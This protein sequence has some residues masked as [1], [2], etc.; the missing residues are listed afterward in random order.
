MRDEVRERIHGIVVVIVFVD[1]V[2]FSIA[3]FIAV[4]QTKKNVRI[5]FS[6]SR[7]LHDS[8]GHFTARQSVRRLVR[9]K[10]V[11]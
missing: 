10:L 1:V 11:L 6:F 9:L 8:I 3:Q 5:M 4:E 7:V 2:V